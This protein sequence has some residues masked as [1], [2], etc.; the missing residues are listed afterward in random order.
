MALFSQAFDLVADRGL[1]RRPHVGQITPFGRF[2]FSIY[3][4]DMFRDAI[5]QPRRLGSLGLAPEVAAV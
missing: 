5:A 4:S 2:D 3:N 1:A